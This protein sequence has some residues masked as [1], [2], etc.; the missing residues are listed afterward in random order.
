MA[1]PPRKPMAPHL[2]A[3]VMLAHDRTCCVCNVPGK[4]VQI[5]HID[6]DRSNDNYDN[7]AV[8]CLQ[9]HDDTQVRGGFAKR[10]TAPLVREYRREW[11]KRV[12]KRKHET[13]RLV[14]EARVL[15]M[16]GESSANAENID[17][18]SGAYEDRADAPE[19]S[20][21]E[22]WLWASGNKDRE[23]LI[24]FPETYLQA[25]PLIQKGYGGS[26]MEM[27]GSAYA[28]IDLLTR[29]WLDAFKLLPKVTI[30]EQGAESYISEYTQSRFL[31]HRALAEPLGPG[32][33]G[34][35]VGP[36]S[37]GHVIGDLQSAVSETASAVFYG[38]EWELADVWKERWDSACKHEQDDIV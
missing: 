1:K 5:H 34:S 25:L 8:L 38:D 2:S 28:E 12:E 10:L 32:T 24:S 31:W 20:E 7:L 9:D 21:R 11:L 27:M 16:R 19:Y 23:Q 4:A 33:G 15:V 29:L 3:R 35:I 14:I 26:T 37:A 17:V 36:V 6:D 22:L 18:S 30:A 13:D